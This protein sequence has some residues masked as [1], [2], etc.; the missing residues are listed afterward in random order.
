MS[1]SDLQQ[2]NTFQHFI[3][4]NALELPKLCRSDICE[5]LFNVQSI[6]AEIDARKLLFLGRLCRLDYDALPKKIFLTRLMSFMLDLSNKQNGFIPDIVTILHLYDLANYLQDWLYHGIFPTKDSWKKIV[7]RAVKSSHDRNRER[8]MSYDSDFS[9]FRIIYSK[10]I[11][12]AIWKLPTTPDEISLCKFIAKLCTN[13]HCNHNENLFICVLCNRTFKDV[14]SHCSCTC[15]VTFDLRNRWWSDIIN[16]SDI[17]LVAE[18][19]GLSED[20]LYMI[21]IGRHTSTPIDKIF[22]ASFYLAN[23]RLVRSCAAHYFRALHFA[24]T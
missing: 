10:F 20:D 3:C 21:L 15:P 23:F 18:L 7:R 1:S 6:S 19:S 2:L 11:P 4:K 16:Y 8:R 13:M 22:H 24:C 17:S 5:S 14:F 9:F 12:A